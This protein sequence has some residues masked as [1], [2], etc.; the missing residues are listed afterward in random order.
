MRTYKLFVMVTHE[1]LPQLQVP[2]RTLA[3]EANLGLGGTHVADPAVRRTHLRGRGRETVMRYATWPL[4]MEGG[5]GTYS[6]ELSFTTELLN[7]RATVNP[8]GGGGQ[9]VH[10]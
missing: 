4:D 6:F 10:H 2:V 3:H 1:E 8:G 9:C 5:G 7:A